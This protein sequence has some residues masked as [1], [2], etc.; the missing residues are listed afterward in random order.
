MKTTIYIILFIIWCF[1]TAETKIS[2][3]PFSISFNSP[4]LVLAWLLVLAGIVCFSVHYDIKA[5]KEVTIKVVEVT[6]P[7]AYKKGYIDAIEDVK[8]AAKK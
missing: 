1:F 4:Y 8:S 7:K 3:K 2:I 5:T 6:Y